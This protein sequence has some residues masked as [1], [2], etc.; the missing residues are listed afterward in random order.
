[1]NAPG[2]RIRREKQTID[3][4]MHIY[5][6][7][8]HGREGGLCDT[9]GP[10]LDYARRRLDLCPFGDEKPACNHCQ[11]H[12]YSASMRERVR[13]VMRYSGPRMLWH[14]PLLSLLH[15][16]DKLR[17]VPR[18]LSG[19]RVRSEGARG[20]GRFF[21]RLRRIVDLSLTKIGRKI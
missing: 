18:S 2:R 12:C 20:R 13:S 10:L 17:R 7:D 9:C 21:A 8:H 3:A 4:M 19:L 15:M 1:M 16:L 11:V 14:H 6:H 5:C